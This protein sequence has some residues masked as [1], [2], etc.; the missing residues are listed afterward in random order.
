MLYAAIVAIAAVSYNVDLVLFGRFVDR[1]LA[2]GL[3]DVDNLP[4]S[5]WPRPRKR[6]AIDATTVFKWSAGS[7]YVRDIV[8]P[9]YQRY[10]LSLAF[11]SFF[12]SDRNTILF[13]TLPAGFW[14]PFE[15]PAVR[16]ALAGARDDLDRRFL[17]FLSENYCVP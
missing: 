16:R 2:A 6:A 17:K 5:E 1:H 3:T 15:C 11:Y 13:H 14:T 10:I 7:D 4:P 8:V 9:D 12:R